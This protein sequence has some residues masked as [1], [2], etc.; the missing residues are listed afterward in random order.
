ME[1]NHLMNSKPRVRD[2]I[3]VGQ[4]Y[5]AREFKTYNWNPFSS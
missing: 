2:V 5:L 1:K 3:A 4:Q